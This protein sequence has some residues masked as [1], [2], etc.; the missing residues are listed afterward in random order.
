MQ[1]FEKRFDV[2][3]ITVAFLIGAASFYFIAS[4]LEIIKNIY[5][6]KT[7]DEQTSVAELSSTKNTVKRKPSHLPVWYPASEKD[8][9]FL[10]DQVFTDK[11]SFA[12]LSFQDKTSVDLDQN[13][14]IVIERDDKN[15]TL[16][17]LQGEVVVNFTKAPSKIVDK[18]QTIRPVEIK[19]GKT[20]V[21]L[22]KQTGEVRI[23][24]TNDGTAALTVVSGNVQIVS[25]EKS[26][27]VN[28]NE[29][30]EIKP[31]VKSAKAEAPPP[32][33]K[34]PIPV[35]LES[36]ARNEEVFF[37]GEFKSITFKWTSSEENRKVTL[38]I[39]KDRGFSNIFLSYD[40]QEQIHTVSNLSEGPWFWRVIPDGLDVSNPF[41]EVRMLQLIKE[42]PPML[43]WP[44]HEY[45][46]SKTIDDLMIYFDWQSKTTKS[47]IFHL[48]D[49]SSFS[50]IL[51]KEDVSHT[52]FYYDVRSFI[53][54]EAT[55]QQKFF[56]R[57]GIL[58]N[59]KTVLWSPINSF[60]IK[61]I[62]PPS[63]V[64]QSPKETPAEVIPELP[65][66]KLKKEF[67][68]QP[69]KKQSGFLRQK[70]YKFLIY[71]GTAYAQSEHIEHEIAWDAV[72]NAK[73]YH[74]IVSKDESF[75]SILIDKI[76]TES[77]VDFNPDTPGT[78]YIKVATI[79]QKDVAG[80][81]SEPSMIINPEIE[82]PVETTTPLE[83]PIETPPETQTAVPT[84]TPSAT[85]LVTATPEP[86]LKPEPKPIL[87]PP[88]IKAPTANEILTFDHQK[89]SYPL[90]LSWGIVPDASSYE[91]QLAYKGSFNDPLLKK[92][93]NLT[94]LSVDMEPGEYHWRV[95]V[96]NEDKKAGPW[97]G[98]NDFT[99]K[100]ELPPTPEPEPTSKSKQSPEPEVTE[101][102]GTEPVFIEPKQPQAE[103]MF[104]SHI[105]DGA[106]A[107]S[108]LRYELTST[109]PKTKLDGT[110]LSSGFIHGRFVINERSFINALFFR[111][112]MPIDDP[113]DENKT[114]SYAPHHLAIKYN[115]ALFSKSRLFSPI[116][117]GGYLYR[118][119][120][121]FRRETGEPL[122]LTSH[123]T[124]SLMI[125]MGT[126]SLF[127]ASTRLFMHVDY[128]YL[129]AAI[130]SKIQS[131][132]QLF[133][134]IRLEHQLQ[135]YH[136]TTLLGCY[137][138]YG[139]YNI[140][141]SLD[142]SSGNIFESNISP[143]IGAGFSF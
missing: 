27:D 52:P 76:V 121:K 116:L 120:E 132:L 124:H 130:S 139:K 1:N 126:M 10:K 105:V 3:L 127:S 39:G 98:S 118:K 21:R 140:P 80:P 45:T 66:P 53:K 136:V 137:Y 106:W 67:R 17:I 26:I 82:I 122:S 96:I 35:I 64:T 88:K 14:L 79:N 36:P 19:S 70:I 56:W 9:L 69:K 89:T 84:P 93:T 42:E 16:D 110:L 25:G 128:A 141:E 24:K 113:H 6:N 59:K 143:Y 81:F 18:K 60:S 54:T 4:D 97:T 115:Y 77:F 101:P 7:T 100:K 11:D 119:V 131:N 37:T 133:L 31:E 125:G 95:R 38:Q 91:V 63:V 40:L 23:V 62:T 134:N 49:E 71:S 78:F 94:D 8:T 51:L 108:I 75:S 28:K 65:P 129:A 103:S 33:V 87:G 5:E 48:S 112:T 43:T 57:V 72:I 22:E 61:A 32:I 34:K 111:R 123:Q 109:N 44:P 85:P 50:K 12:K 74:V 20:R 30:V 2:L 135:W 107:P 46:F 47:Y 102:M 55:D 15:T 13:T 114:L 138:D 104:M 90:T 117:Q 99:V 58:S 73:A 41:I 86:E 92:Q 29:T 83:T 68:L 142:A